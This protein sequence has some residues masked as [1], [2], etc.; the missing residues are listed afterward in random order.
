M[1]I[2]WRIGLWALAA[3]SYGAFVWHMHTVFDQAAEAKKLAEQIQARHEAEDHAADLSKELER[4]LAAGRLTETA[5]TL[6]L[7]AANAKVTDDCRVPD[8]VIRLL[9]QAADNRAGDSPR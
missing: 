7:E 9:N 8:D 5:L 1:T 3:F 2:W 4:A 6:Q